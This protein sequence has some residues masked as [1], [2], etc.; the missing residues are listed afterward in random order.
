MSFFV[1]VFSFSLFSLSL[2]KT[3][4]PSSAAEI[5]PRVTLMF[6]QC[7]NV[8]SLA[9]KALAS[10]RR[11]VAMVRKKREQRGRKRSKSRASGD[12]DGND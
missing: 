11:S 12:D 10:V 4:S 5:E 1:R 7:R 9:K 8:R 2:P 6:I 3:S